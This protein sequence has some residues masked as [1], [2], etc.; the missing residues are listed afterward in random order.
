MKN[1]HIDDLYYTHFAHTYGNIY[2][3][4]LVV[5]KHGILNKRNKQTAGSSAGKIILQPFFKRKNFI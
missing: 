2:I 4:A 3:N 5:H 1:E